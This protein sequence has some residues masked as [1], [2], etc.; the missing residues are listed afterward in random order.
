MKNNPFDRRDGIF[1]EPYPGES[2][3]DLKC[4][5]LEKEFFRYVADRGI[6]HRRDL[7]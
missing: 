1:R 2:P 5:R 6:S 3:G 7:L 4:D